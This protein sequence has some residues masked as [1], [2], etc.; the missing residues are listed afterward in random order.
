MELRRLWGADAWLGN[1]SI[2]DGEPLGASN[3]QRVDD[4]DVVGFQFEIGAA[5][6]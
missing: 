1:G 3:K 6:E 5:R 2:L 4:F